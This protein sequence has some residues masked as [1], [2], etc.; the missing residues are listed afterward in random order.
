MKLRARP[1]DRATWEQVAE[2]EGRSLSSW[3]EST[4]NE[5]AT[6]EIEAI[7]LPEDPEYAVTEDGQV[8]SFKTGR[9][10]RLAQSEDDGGYLRVQLGG[11]QRGV[12]VIV[13]LAFRGPPEEGQVCR[14]LD[15][16]PANN[17]LENLA[18]GTRSENAHDAI[19]HR[20]MRQ[21]GL[22]PPIPKRRT[23][24][25][26]L[27]VDQKSLEMYQAAADE[28]GLSRNAWAN[29]VLRAAAG[30]EPLPEYMKRTVV[31][32]DWEDEPRKVRDGNW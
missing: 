31:I 9:W 3:I 17:H 10:Q 8:F 28:A 14:H 4:A 23:R 20:K 18:W 25:F 27:R 12:H 26:G 6:L 21:A 24:I 13:L 1:S 19:K 22:W 30:L 2:E 5:A 15:G 29:A 16:N 7:R 11:R 32:S